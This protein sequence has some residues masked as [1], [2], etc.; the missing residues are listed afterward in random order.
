MCYLAA[1]DRDAHGCYAWKTTQG[2]HLVSI[3]KELNDAVG[4][5][6]IELVTI[7]RPTAFGEYA[8]Y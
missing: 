2:K 1:K 8:P 4:W 5:K 3:K 6:G 7:S